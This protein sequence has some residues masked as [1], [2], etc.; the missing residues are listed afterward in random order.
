MSLLCSALYAKFPYYVVLYMQSVLV[1]VGAGAAELLALLRQLRRYPMDLA[2]PRPPLVMDLARPR[3]PPVIH[4]RRI[5]SCYGH[6]LY[7]ETL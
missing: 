4:V 2:R 1:T 3:P 5:A 7:P 6:I